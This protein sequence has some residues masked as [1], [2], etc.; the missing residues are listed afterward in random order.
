MVSDVFFSRFS[1]SCQHIELQYSF[2]ARTMNFVFHDLIRLFLDYIYERCLSAD[3]LK[4]VT[5]GR[6]TPHAEK[7]DRY[8]NIKRIK[9]R[10]HADNC[11]KVI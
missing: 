2:L 3:G 9:F 1:K 10:A 11:S 5:A 4:S 7:F 6:E 8:F